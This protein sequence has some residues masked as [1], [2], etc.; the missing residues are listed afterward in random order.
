MNRA[1]LRRAGLGLSTLL[2]IRPGG[3]LIPYRHAGSARAEGYPALRPIFSAAE[4]EFRAVLAAIEAHAAGLDRI[5]AGGPGLV[6]ERPA[7]F[8]QDWFPRLDAAA[9]YA[10][11]RRERPR[12]IVEIGS[13][14]STRFLAQAVRDG[15]LA[16]AITCIDPAP[17]APLSGLGLHHEA[18][19]FGPEDAERAATL[20]PGDAL[21]IDSSH[22][23][24]PGT[25]VDRLLLD[26]MPRLKPGVL[27]HLHD[28]FLPD[29]Y[30]P[31]WAWRGYNEQ[32]LVGALLQGSGYTPLFASHYVASCSGWPP[33]G[34][35]ARLPL[36]PEAR[37]SSLWLR[38]R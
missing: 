29:A 4:P 1:R 22:V 3:F 16:T 20:E 23:A 19:L 32:L 15:G 13:G 10:L 12:R 31:D 38:K 26:V 11:V 27:V 5:L 24:M 2:G 30:P 18:R 17:R 33:A 25:D 7:R 37:E 14:H 35:L 28:I 36:L 34:I 8:T 9:A 21:F 6:G